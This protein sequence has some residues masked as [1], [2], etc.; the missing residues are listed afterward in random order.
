[1]QGYL[2]FGVWMFHVA[3]LHFSCILRLDNSHFIFVDECFVLPYNLLVVLLSSTRDAG[4]FFTFVGIAMRGKPKEN[5]SQ[6]SKNYGKKKLI[7]HLPFLADRKNVLSK[8]SPSGAVL[9]RIGPRI[10][11]IH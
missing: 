7:S 11:V 3:Y 4:M 8:L 5:K 10:E 6:S 9:V 2:H 1:M